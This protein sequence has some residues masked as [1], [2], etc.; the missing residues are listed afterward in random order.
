M[1]PDSDWAQ[2][3]VDHDIAYWC[4]GSADERRSA[5]LSLQACVAETGRPTLGWWMDKGVRM[6]GIPWTPTSWRWGYGWDWPTGYASETN[7][8]DPSAE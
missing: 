2:C 7:E 6:G 8:G 4:G 1:F 5:D 3:C